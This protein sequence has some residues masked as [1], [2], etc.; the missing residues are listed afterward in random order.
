MKW[1][2]PWLAVLAISCGLSAQAQEE[3]YGGMLEGFDYPALVQKF[4]FKSQQLDMHMAYLDIQSAKA[5]GHVVVLLHG[6]N[7]CAATWQATYEALQG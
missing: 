6:K 5:N 3:I 1:L 2:R 4:A 7:F